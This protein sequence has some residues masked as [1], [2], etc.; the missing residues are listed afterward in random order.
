LAKKASAKKPKEKKAEPVK[1]VSDQL[2][3]LRYL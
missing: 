3:T 2:K 1:D